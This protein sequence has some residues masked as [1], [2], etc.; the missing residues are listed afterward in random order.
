MAPRRPPPGPATQY[1]RFVKKYLRER[2]WLQ[3]GFQQ[4]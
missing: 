3:P 4:P 2:I 1:I